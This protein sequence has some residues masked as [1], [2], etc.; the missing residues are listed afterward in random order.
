[1]INTLRTSFKIDMSY[2]TNS[3]IYILR[4]LPILKDLITE[5][6]YSSKVL[7]SIVRIIS[8]IFSFGKMLAYK[9]L[10]FF[11]LIGLANLLNE[12]F[13]GYVFIHIYFVLTL[14]GMFINNR[15]ISPNSKK[16]FSVILF[17]M[18]A[19]KYTIS[20]F[21]YDL[22]I[23][24]LLNLI[25]LISIKGMIHISFN[26]IYLLLICSLLCRIIGEAFSIIFY[27]RYRYLFNSNTKLYMIISI[28]FLGIC[29]LPYFGIFILPNM[30]LLLLIPLLGLSILSFI[31]ILRC[32]DYKIIIKETN[33]YNAIMNKDEVSSYNRQKMVEVR[34]KDKII[35]NKKIVGKHGYDLFN[36]IF[37]ERHREILLRSALR[38]SIG[39]IGVYI[40]LSI[41]YYMGQGNFIHSFLLNNMGWF[42]LILYFVNRG[43][44]ITQAMFYNSDH[45]MLRYNFYREES[46]ILGLF[47]RRLGTVVKVNLIPGIL[48][49]VGNVVL[50]FI[51]GGA[52]IITYI[53]MFIFIISLCIFFSVHYLVLYYLL[54]PYNKDLMIKSGTYSFITLLTYF[55]SYYA[56]DIKV[57]TLLFSIFGIVFCIIYII[58][59][60]LLVKKYA[61]RTFRIR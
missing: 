6:A 19:K 22:F 53:S 60:L 20:T 7:K 36:T 17:G 18:D 50:L 16:Y 41:M 44:I 1:M 55:V 38:F 8:L 27:K 11:I 52:D 26:T 39:I 42:V 12:R 48:I 35:D 58:I 45:A 47:K 40:V 2:A 54:Q 61:P 30:I 29:S 5:D 57:S 13:T 9:F 4:K 51:T 21:I 10:Y 59:G 32:R 24:T 28:I 23:T 46:V 25:V 31:Y 34:D 33:S 49:A 3:F 56:S 37:F 14:L 43:S 15:L